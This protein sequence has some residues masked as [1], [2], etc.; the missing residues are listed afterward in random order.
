M[1][2]ADYRFY[3]DIFR[4]IIIPQEDF[5][6]LALRA[7]MRL[8]SLTRGRIA[9]WAAQYPDD[10]Q[11]ANAECAVAEILYRAERHRADAAPSIKTEIVGEHHVTYFEP[12]NRD[13][14]DREI[15]RAAT[16]HLLGTGLMFRGV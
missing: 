4:G 7:K 15:A 10:R 14:L 16:D 5:D 12:E 13:E 9:A 6:R 11:T 1:A 3:T 2:N 8:E